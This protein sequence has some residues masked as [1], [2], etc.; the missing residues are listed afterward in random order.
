MNVD[1]ILA[2]ATP[3]EAAEIDAALA[4]LA[5]MRATQ[6]TQRERLRLA[7]TRLAAFDREIAEIERGRL[8]SSRIDRANAILDGRDVAT[9]ADDS[10]RLTQIREDR[11]AVVQ[12]RDQIKGESGRTAEVSAIVLR[13]HVALQAPSY[14]V[15]RAALVDVAEHFA[16]VSGGS[17]QGQC[18]PGVWT[19]APQINLADMGVPLPPTHVYDTVRRIVAAA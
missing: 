3:E 1:E 4:A 18:L 2:I 19:V 6:A 17:F 10:A 11:A 16:I 15:L 13:A 8:R 5:A 7:E 14:R 9:L 12:L